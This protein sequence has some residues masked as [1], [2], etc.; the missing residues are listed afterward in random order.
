MVLKAAKIG[1]I[2]T[3]VMGANMAGHLMRKGG[4]NL[5]VFN[6][7]ASKADGLVK[8]GASFKPVSQI[9]EESDIIC[10]ML[11]Y[12]HDVEKM[13]LDPQTGL[14]T[15]MRPGSYLIDHTTSTPSLAQKIAEAASKVG[16]NS[17]DAPVTGGDVGARNGT[18]VTMV[19]GEPNHLDHLR[20]LLETYSAE[21]GHFGAAGSGQH[22]KAANQIMVAQNLLGLCESLVYGHKAG[23]DLDKM[24]RMLNKGSA[25]SAQI[26]NFGARI[27]RRDFAPGFYVEHLVKDL[28]I[29]FDECEKMNLDL[30]GMRLCK[31]LMEE[32]EA[33]GGGRNG[34]H[35]LI[36]VLEKIN[37]IQ[38][39]TYE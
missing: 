34:T 22:T 27:L 14:L 38:V 13:V 6:R 33:M 9:A 37:K 17:V 28:G 31:Q 15:R 16:V 35:G 39:K 18:L 26:T 2:G 21:I 20:P 8:A 25:G 7:T 19:G 1:W 3:G 32:Y 36:E 12:P 24:I 11:G 23:L 30:P 10:M 4:C 29:C 5:S